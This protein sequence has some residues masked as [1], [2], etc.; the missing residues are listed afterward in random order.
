MI[1]LLASI[2]F[3]TL[4]TSQHI[5]ANLV[6]QSILGAFT[7]FNG[8]DYNTCTSQSES[9]SGIGKTDHCPSYIKSKVK[10]WRIKHR[11]LV[12]KKL[13][14]KKLKVMK[15]GRCGVKDGPLFYSL[16]TRW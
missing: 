5:L 14:R 1:S 8:S 10:E 4:I 6:H 3:L 9:T 11:S 13:K 12:N 15:T 16:E 2:A 7:Y